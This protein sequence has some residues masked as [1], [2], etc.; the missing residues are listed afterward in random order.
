MKARI[1]VG[2]LLIL[3]L[4]L[5]LT[6]CQN[7]FNGFEEIQTS[8]DR[9]V[10]NLHAAAN[11]SMARNIEPDIPQ[12]TKFRLSF[13]SLDADQTA[14]DDIESTTGFFR[15]VELDPGS[16]RI[17]AYGYIEYEGSVQIVAETS[18]EIS[19]EA[20]QVLNEEIILGSPS[21][22]EGSGLFS[23]SLELP[24]DTGI[25][26][27]EITLRSYPTMVQR[28]SDSETDL[29][30]QLT[31]YSASAEAE[32]E[33]GYYFASVKVLNDSGSQATESH[34]LRIAENRTTSWA[35]S[36]QEDSFLPI[37][38]MNGNVEVLVNGSSENVEIEYITLYWNEERHWS[39]T[40]VGQWADEDGNWN[41][42]LEE[43]QEETDLYV[44]IEYRYNGSWQR[45]DPAETIRVHNSDIQ[46]LQLNYA[47]ELIG[48]GG[49]LDFTANV[50]LDDF[51]Y[52]YVD[53]Y[54][55]EDRHWGSRI[56]E[57]M[58]QE[59][60]SW[61]FAAE[62]FEAETLY[63]SLS[64]MYMDVYVQLEISDFLHEY[65]DS[66][67]DIE[68]SYHADLVVWSGSM[69]ILVNGS[70]AGIE[71]LWVQAR[72]IEDSGNYTYLNY[73]SLI[74]DSGNWRLVFKSLEESETIEIT[75]GIRYSGTWY[76]KLVKTI[77][78]A[79][80]E[81]LSDIHLFYDMQIDED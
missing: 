27:Y 4:I 49:T 45:L 53:V 24:A 47:T 71:N 30:I 8:N 59:D 39:Q 37:I 26:E 77:H 51:E 13:E 48:I 43:L 46:N 2:F 78:D 41:F 65:T 31:P 60:G 34:I 74:D 62:P 52:L 3:G 15:G 35:V 7:L 10:L 11:E 32:L 20:G 33:A 40:A 76:N 38:R 25:T 66:N 12:F 36:I 68:L 19:A 42:S 56:G 5:S 75:V 18:L 29:D 58:V 72:Y 21:S 14:Q 16:W 17:H 1:V 23:W 50:S 67:E 81:D 73:N 64:F 9:M 55:S 80:M 57:A 70:S 28:Y 63:F 61:Y 22:N 54:S 79:G 69:E 44:R 6:A